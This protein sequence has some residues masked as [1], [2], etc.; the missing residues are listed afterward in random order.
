MADDTR[1]VQLKS[2]FDASGVRKGVDDAKDAL[3]DLATAAQTSG[4]KAGEGVRAAGEGAEEAAGKVDKGTRSIIAGIQ[5]VSAQMSAGEKNTAGYFEA[6]AKQRGANVD[7]LKPYIEDLRKAEEAQRKASGSLNLMGVSAAQ[8]NAALRTLPA[9]FT[10]IITSLQGGQAPLTVLLQQGGQIKDSFGGVGNALKVVT[11]FITPLRVA[12]GGAAGAAIALGVAYNQGAKES[13]EYARAL[14]LT[15]NAAGTTRDQLAD[16]AQAIGRSVGTQGDAAAAL[17]ALASSGQVAAGG[18]GKAAEAAVRLER[19]GV[20]SIDKTVAAFADLGRKPLEASLKLNESTNY[21]T[22]SLIEQIGALEKQGKAA[23]AAALAQDAFATSMISRSAEI[24]ANLGTIEKAWRGIKEGAASAWD[25]MLGIGRPKTIGDQLSEAGKEVER[26]RAGAQRRGTERTGLNDNTGRLEGAL[27]TQSE[28]QELERLNRRSAEHQATTAATVKEYAKASEGVKRWTDLARTGT[29][30]ANE[31]L[32]EYRRDIATKNA[33]LARD[34]LPTISAAEIKKTEAAIVA[35]FQKGGG[36]AKQAFNEQLA[37]FKSTQGVLDQLTKQ[38]LGDLQSQAVQGLVSQREAIEGRTNLEV[39][40]AERR[41]EILR[42]ELAAANSTKGAE[43]ERIDIAGKLGAVAAEVAGIQKRGENEVLELLYKQ[44]KAADDVLAAQ[45]EED[46]AATIAMLQREAEARKQGSLAV[47]EYARG[48]DA[49]IERTQLEASLIGQSEQVRRVAIEQFQIELELRKQIEAIN[50]NSGFDQAQHDQEIARARAASARAA[51]NAEQKVA[52]DEWSKTTDQIG[53]SLTDALMNGGKSAWEYLKGL[54]RS[55]V[56]RPIIQAVVAPITGGLSSAVQAFTGGG[57]G[58]GGQGGF[59]DLSKLFGGGGGG[60]FDLSSVY[61]KLSEGLSGSISNGFAQ[62]SASG[63][64]QSLGLSQPIADLTGVVSNIPT[65]LSNSLGSILGAGGNAFAAYGISKTLSGGYS[66][67][68]G[69]ALNNIAAAASF[70]PGVGPIAGIVTGTINRL[71]GRKLADQGIEGTL[72]GT[73]GFEGS[74]TQFMKGG[75]LRSDK[76]V[77]TALDAEFANPLAASVTAIKKTVSDYAAALKL[78]VDQVDGYTEAIK[79]STKGLSPE[80]VQAKL[81]EA[82]TGFGEGLANQFADELGPFKREGEKTADALSRLAG[83]LGAVNPLLEQLNLQVF[84]VGVA[85]ADAASQLADQFGGAAQLAQVASSYFEQYFSEAEKAAKSTEQITDTLAGV[86]LALPATRDEFRKLVEAQDLT[87]TSGRDAFSALLKVSG[88]FADLTPAVEEAAKAVDEAAAA[89]RQQLASAIDSNINK[90]LT[91][92]QQTQR[93][94]GQI[95]GNLQAAG[96]N[97]DVSQLF[98]ASKAQ[99]FDFATSFVAAAENTDAAKIAVVQAAGALADLKDQ[100]TAAA[101]A[102]QD[103]AD[104]EALAAAQAA[105]ALR[106]SVAS[107]LDGVIAQFVSGAALAEYRATRI[108]DQLKAGGID[109]SA[110]GVLG[111]SKQDIVALW[112]SVGDESRLVIAS[113]Y[114]DW[115]ALQQG[116]AQSRIDTFLGGLGVSADELSSAYD[117]LNPKADNLVVSWRKSRDEMQTL[118]QALAQIDG[119][120]AVSALDALRATIAQRDG[121]RNVIGGNSQRIFDLRVGQ[122]GTQAV[123]LLRKREADL[124]REFASTNSPEVAQAI[125]D[126][127]LQRIKLEGDVQAQANAAQ[128]DALRE[129]ISAAE[130]LRDVAAEMGGFIQSLKAGSL[131]NLSATD[132]LAVQQQIFDQSLTTGADVQGNAQTLLQQAQQTY[133]GSS[134]Q[135][136]A[137]FDATMAQLEALGLT[138]G[139]AS[140]QISDA[141]AQIDAL[142]RVSDT[143]D[144]QISALG[145]LNEVFGGGLA[146]LTTRA[147]EQTQVQRDQLAALQTSVANQ[148][149]QITQAGEGLQRMVAALEAIAESVRTTPLDAALLEATS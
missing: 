123:E 4:A 84:A 134:T 145:T 94:Y 143:S 78:P 73:A 45:R 89:M 23:Q 41:M 16:M 34:G 132:R 50:A 108:A 26:L 32:A 111:A 103:A 64:G 28:V 87:T 22:I 95:A 25:T 8:T 17:A 61:S 105:A 98:G 27:Q 117:E 14:I 104:A 44:R 57:G 18:I 79:F 125:T 65:S 36:A 74:S 147:E 146:T 114:D 93:Q 9:Q 47:Y 138:G 21:L 19:E 46:N 76:T 31:A 99:I 127:T 11:S 128:I 136:S 10:D 43:K 68:G 129:Q 91:P 81:Q 121:L 67:T 77:K 109:A 119:T 90:F 97:V 63:F 113:L 140:Q 86:G 102:T 53:Q 124:W 33:G 92:E 80:Q 51:L 115:V 35:S 133:G 142:T 60:G 85:G 59:G 82:L 55:T 126:L 49:T 139:Q 62:F 42:G 141:Q 148:E 66:V 1:K 137:I 144:A 56:L 5:R 37:I 38:A 12:I 30:K 3:K 75:F 149:V 39:Q 110:A 71:F 122:G 83:N 106:T 107:A 135:Y 130:R 15:G 101:K 58:G 112:Q 100:A 72:G 120:E 116:I 7:T 2:E 96:V 52:L 69:N 54:F 131:S 29:E 40:S 13:Q 88:A 6:L 20:Q 70:I 24:E 48:I 118:S